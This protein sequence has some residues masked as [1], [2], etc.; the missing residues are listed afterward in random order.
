MKNEQIA[1]AFSN[2]ESTSDK[3]SFYVEVVEGVTIAFSYGYHFP[4]CI[5]FSDGVLFNT[6]GYSNTTARHKN[7]ILATINHD[8]TDDEK[9]NT[10]QIKAVVDKI[11]YQG[12]KTK[13]EIIEQK[14]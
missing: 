8:L 2:D 9:M 12:V 10:Q 5:K 7:L 3:K 11:R 1:Q 6:D 4:I 13:A 14:I